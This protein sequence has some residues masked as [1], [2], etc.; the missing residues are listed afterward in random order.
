MNALALVTSQLIEFSRRW[1]LIASAGIA[2]FLS[3]K[4]IFI[5]DNY[6]QSVTGYPVFDSQNDLSSTK[7]LQQLPLY[8]GKGRSLYLAFS[9]FDFLFPFIASLFL[10]ILWALF[11]RLHTSTIAKKLITWNLPI[12]PFVATLADYGENIFLLTAVLSMPT[13]TNFIVL[14]AIAFKKLKLF[15]LILIGSTTFILAIALLINILK[16]HLKRIGR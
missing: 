5:L 12:F 2:T 8:N 13:S 16:R 9:A 7:L 3:L 15:G 10:A 11:L 1:W 6:F 14:G 4:L